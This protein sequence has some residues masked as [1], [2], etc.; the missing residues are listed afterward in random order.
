[1]KITNEDVLL[2]VDVQRDFCQGGSL[3]VSEGDVIVPILNEYIRKISTAKGHVYLSRDWHPEDHVSFL[4]QNGPWPK[5]CV[6]NSRGAEF[7]DDLILPDLF[8]VISKGVDP[9]TEAYSAFQGTYL[10]SDLKSRSVKRLFVGGLATDV[11]VKETILD[12]LKEG[13]VVF[14]LEDAS[15]GVSKDGIDETYKLLR[16]KGVGFVSLKNFA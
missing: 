1:M 13:F 16:D 8:T 14:F 5:H 3:E 7:H 10:S 6:A 11:C 15:R 4:E 2:I 12:A 9:D